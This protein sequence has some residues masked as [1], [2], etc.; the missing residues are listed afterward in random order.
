MI[1][2]RALFDTLRVPWR[3][4][5][6]NCSRGHV[7]VSC[8]WC[9]RL[10]PSFHLTI[11]ED[12]GEYY[13]LRTP[14][15]MHSGKSLPWLLIGLGA[16]PSEID[17]LI[18]EHTDHT[19]PRS[20]VAVPARIVPWDRF[21]PAGDHEAALDYLASRGYADPAKIAARFD[22][23]FTKVGRFA[24]RILLPLSGP[25]DL[26][27]TI[28]FTGRA[29]RS[30]T[31]RYLT[32]DSVG[33]SLYAVTS[34]TVRIVALQGTAFPI[35]KKLYLSHLTRQLWTIIMCEGPFDALTLSLANPALPPGA[36]YIPDRDQSV[37]D[38]Y[39]LITELESIPS[40]PH[41]IRLELPGRHRDLGEMAAN[42]QE[43]RQWLSDLPFS[44]NHMSPSGRDPSGTMREHS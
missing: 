27:S 8:P 7:N 43:I 17:A 30:Q 19:Q 40:M 21:D 34:G 15:S 4:R 1:A 10:D 28:A 12:T 36:F 44:G 20:L 31:P 9:G 25:G 26:G 14:G 39:R 16:D 11:R 33:G 41:I 6:S 38:T 29:I 2:W 42:V 23:R 18:E 5:G 24:W 37:S 35:E 22:L 32:N 3:D 13:C